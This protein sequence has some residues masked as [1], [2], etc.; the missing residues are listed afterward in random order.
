MAAVWVVPR[1]PGIGANLSSVAAKPQGSRHA[2][3]PHA[4]EMISIMSGGRIFARQA[5]AR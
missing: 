2:S 4:D 1:G 3:P 5:A